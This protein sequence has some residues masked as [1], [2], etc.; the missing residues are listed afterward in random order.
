MHSS[1]ICPLLC[2][3]SNSAKLYRAS[4][5]KAEGRR[6]PGRGFKFTSSFSLMGSVTP[7]KTSFGGLQLL[8]GQNPKGLSPGVSPGACTPR[9]AI[10]LLPSAICHLPSFN[11]DKLSSSNCFI[12][13][14]T[15]FSLGVYLHF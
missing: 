12:H 1:H 3:P 5:L 15:L 14:Q 8:V 11:A 2:Y 10:V 6:L 9:P 13:C 4:P 7:A